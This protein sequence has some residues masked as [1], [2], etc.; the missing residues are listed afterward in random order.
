MSR[1]AL[2]LA[3]FALVIAGC[4]GGDEP[5][6][7]A[8]VPGGGSV[9][10]VAKEYSFDPSAIVVRAPGAVKITLSNEGSLAHNLKLTK[11]GRE[12]GGTPAFP[13]GQ[14]E[15]VRMK[16]PRGEYEFLC[17][18]GDHAELGMKGTLRVD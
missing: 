11:D 14:A 9:R 10:V 18:V 7:T 2:T 17:T 8:T 3:A 15:S 5:G 16:L 13:S 6:R 1:P 4:G 12:L